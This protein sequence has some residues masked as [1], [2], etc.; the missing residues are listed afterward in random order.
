LKADLSKQSLT[1]LNKLLLKIERQLGTVGFTST[2]NNTLLW[3][4]YVDSFDE[5]FW[6]RISHG[7]DLELYSQRVDR[8]W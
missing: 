2:A 8:Y 3:Q 1:E 4:A 7:N 5:E 6:S